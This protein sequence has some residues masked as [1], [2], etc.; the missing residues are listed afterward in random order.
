M[1][2][3]EQPPE[4]TRSAC[5]GS[6][7]ADHARLSYEYLNDGDL[8]GYASLF[9]KDAVLHRPDLTIRGRTELESFHKDRVGLC[10]HSVTNVIPAASGEHVV[11][12]GRTTEPG[13]DGQVTFAA[14]FTVSSRGLF[15]SQQTF[16]FVPPWPRGTPGR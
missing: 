15:V 16:Y 5:L 10:R 3:D 11:V 14:V 12:L 9:E 7:A 4:E 2:Y 1:T 8:D 13:L 6:A